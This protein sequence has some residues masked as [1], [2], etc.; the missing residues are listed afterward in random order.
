MKTLRR[1]PGGDP[2][3]RDKTPTYSSMQEYMSMSP[4]E[5]G[6]SGSVQNTFG[7][8]D[9]IL[10]SLP[11]HR[12]LAP[13]A[14]KVA[15]M[16]GLNKIGRSA[17]IAREFD[18]PQRYY[19]EYLTM[20]RKNADDLLERHEFYGDNPMLFTPSE[21]MGLVRAMQ[22]MAKENP[23]DFGFFTFK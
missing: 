1:S 9:Y 3:K 15:Q 16:L 13:A 5:R 18:N 2:S 12:V 22:Q 10:G 8:T 11:M 6:G 19:D 4:Y 20:G 21:E 14:Q 7:P 17:R 23:A